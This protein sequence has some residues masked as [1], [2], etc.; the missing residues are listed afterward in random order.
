MTYQA[1]RKSSKYQYSPQ[2]V[3]TL[4][5]ANPVSDTVYTV[6]DTTLDV[7]IHGL[8]IAVTW[9]TTQPTNMRVIVTVDGI[10]KTY[11]VASPISATYYGTAMANYALDSAQLLLSTYAVPYQQALKA[12]SGKSVKIQMAITWA[13]TQ[14]TPLVCYV[15]YARRI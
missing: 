8:G 3:A 1:E 5:Q 4:S 9:A 2:A 15:F 12:I 13:T 14:P 6:L 10:T 11:T 7:K